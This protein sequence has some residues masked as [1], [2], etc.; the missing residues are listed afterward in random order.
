MKKIMLC[1]AVV[2]LCFSCQKPVILSVVEILKNTNKSWKVTRLKKDGVEIN[3]PPTP[4]I[5]QF[6]SNG[7]I[8]TTYKASGVGNAGILGQGDK[9]N[10]F[11]ISN[12]GKWNVVA[13]T[14]VVFDTDGKVS[15]VEFVATPKAGDKRLTIRWTVPEEI[16]KLIPTYEMQLDS[17]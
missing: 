12:E 2:V 6:S 11:S 4:I 8:A 16:D 7:A 15:R 13:G 9:P 5:Y 1:F 10:Y 17:E 3:L 14:A